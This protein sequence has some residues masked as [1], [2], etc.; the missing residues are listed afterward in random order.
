MSLGLFYLLSDLFHIIRFISYSAIR[1]LYDCL[2]DE[3]SKSSFMEIV[4]AYYWGYCKYYYYFYL[5]LVIPLINQS[6]S[7]VFY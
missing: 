1:F 7:I 5:T 3:H 6:I 4:I 2:C